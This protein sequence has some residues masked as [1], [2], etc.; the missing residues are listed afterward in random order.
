MGGGGEG[1]GTEKGWKG[2][3]G[4]R[5]GGDIGATRSKVIIKIRV[6]TGV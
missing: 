4:K 2:K 3:R 6:N 1:K 5:E